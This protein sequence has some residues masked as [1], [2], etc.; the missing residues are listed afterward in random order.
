[1]GWAEIAKTLLVPVIRTP[2]ID[3]KRKAGG[4]Q[5]VNGLP[6]TLTLSAAFPITALRR[7]RL[8]PVKW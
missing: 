6:H 1:M 7:T 5:L 4:P 3:R 8:T 2:V